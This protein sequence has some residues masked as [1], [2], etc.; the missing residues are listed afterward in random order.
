MLW[1]SGWSTSLPERLDSS[2]DHPQRM[3]HFMCNTG[4]AAVHLDPA[5]G[6]QLPVAS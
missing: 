4:G 6:V 5:P 1:E 3:L 2:L